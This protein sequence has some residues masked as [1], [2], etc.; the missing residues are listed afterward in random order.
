MYIYIVLV[1]GSDAV[2][3]DRNKNE[4]RRSAKFV[5]PTLIDERLLMEA[6]MVSKK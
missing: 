1:R 2:R 3:S 4:K 5:F 6:R